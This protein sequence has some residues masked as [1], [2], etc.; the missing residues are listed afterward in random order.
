MTRWRSAFWAPADCCACRST[1]GL[2]LH[3]LL[4]RVMCLQRSPSPAVRFHLKTSGD[5]LLGPKTGRTRFLF[6]VEE[7]QLTQI[8]GLN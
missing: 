3:T 2:D 4:V 7:I 1:D 6:S 8:V 5:P